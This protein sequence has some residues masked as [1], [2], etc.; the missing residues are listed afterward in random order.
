MRSPSP[1]RTPGSPP[2]RPAAGGAPAAAS[3]AGRSRAAVRAALRELLE[4]VLNA[5]GC[6]LDDVVVVPAGRRS[7]VRV[8]VDRDGG[9]SLDDVAA[10]SRAV[11]TALDESDVLGDGPYVLEV[12]SPGVDR[13]LTEARHWRR[14]VG[15]RVRTSLRDGGPVTG[16]VLR[17]SDEGAEVDVDG[18]VRQVSLRDVVKATIEV[19]FDPPRGGVETQQHL[20]ALDDLDDLDDLDEDGRDDG[21]DEGDG[22]VR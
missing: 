18:T 7:V 17:A 9:I 16:R 8:V 1:G 20:E 5:T 10:A 6:E 19:E 22:E 14:A 4:P 15:R 2:R 13:P 3:P 21:D 11:S 12:S